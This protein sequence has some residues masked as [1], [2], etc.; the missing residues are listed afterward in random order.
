MTG[1]TI[2]IIIGTIIFVAVLIFL[3]YWF[4]WREEKIDHSPIKMDMIFNNIPS[5]IMLERVTNKCQD[6]GNGMYTKLYAIT[7]SSNIGVMIFDNSMCSGTEIVAIII[8]S[9]ETL[10]YATGISFTFTWSGNLKAL[11]SQDLCPSAPSGEVTGCTF[12]APSDG[13]Q[14]VRTM[15]KLSIERLHKCHQNN[16]DLTAP[17]NS[18]CLNSDEKIESKWFNRSCAPCSG[19]SNQKDPFVIT[20]KECYYDTTPG[21]SGNVWAMK[22]WNKSD[23][24]SI[25]KCNTPCG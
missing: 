15:G 9:G 20:N 24:S 17:N 11:T 3:L 5:T 2:A 13:C 8:G 16:I 12:K 10:V 1:T 25:R 19:P 4:L 21:E 7:N 23:E 18:F 22:N 14:G 6:I